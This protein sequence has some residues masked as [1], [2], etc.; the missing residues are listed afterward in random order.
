[1]SD[2]YLSPLLL[3]VF[4]YYFEEQGAS[5]RGED[6]MTSRTD[7]GAHSWS[8]LPAHSCLNQLGG[9]VLGE[10]S[11]T[12]ATHVCAQMLFLPLGAREPKHEGQAF[13]RE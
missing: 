4:I 13:T 9:G 2:E 7:G 3:V 6:E 1:M 5:V 11:F 10:S 12:F 8:C